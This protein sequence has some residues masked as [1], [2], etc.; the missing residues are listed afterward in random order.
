MTT[1]IIDPQVQLQEVSQQVSEL[2]QQAQHISIAN[3]YDVSMATEL[4]GQVKSRAKAI[5]ALR[6]VIVQPLNDQVKKINNM[7]KSQIEP[8]EQ[9]ETTVK[10]AVVVFRQMQAEI[11]RKEQEKLETERK[12]EL[13]RLEQERLAA[14]RD[15]APLEVI[16][17]LQAKQED[18][19]LKPV[20]IAVPQA[21]VRT[22]SGTMSAKKVWKFEVTDAIDVPREYL[23]VNETGIRRAIMDGVRD[24]PGVHIYQEESI[25]IR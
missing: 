1:Q 3:D 24:I 16:D 13:Q 4:L 8:L 5:E 11:Q 19:E 18:L 9:I 15:N 20:T 12:A 21:T 22:S 2:Q 17:A 25:S 23:M 7:F 6:V 14:A 10:R